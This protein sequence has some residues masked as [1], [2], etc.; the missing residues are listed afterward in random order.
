[1]GKK[2]K[3]AEQEWVPFIVVVGDKEREGGTFTARV[4]GAAEPVEGNREALVA[5][6]TELQASKPYRPLNTPRLLSLRPVFVG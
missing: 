1:M 3:L 4:R 2:I 6:M 5:Q